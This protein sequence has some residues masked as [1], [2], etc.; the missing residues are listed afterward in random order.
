LPPCLGQFG[1]RKAWVRPHWNLSAEQAL[2]E[3]RQIETLGT[4]LRDQVGLNIG[5]QFDSYGHVTL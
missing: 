4:R 3:L 2:D 5:W 1:G